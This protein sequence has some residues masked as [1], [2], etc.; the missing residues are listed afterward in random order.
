MKKLILLLLCLG[1]WECTAAYPEQMPQIT[2]LAIP[3]SIEFKIVEK[4]GSGDLDSLTFNG[5]TLYLH[6][7]PVLTQA[8]IETMRIRKDDSMSGYLKSLLPSN[9]RPAPTVTLLIRFKKESRAR[10]NEL[11]TQYQGQRMAIIINGSLLQAP[12]IREP[13]KNGEMA[14]TLITGQEE[15]LDKK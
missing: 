5:E 8:D 9:A 1:L 3:S 11:T 10:L 7:E 2:E 4:A 13:L 12:V 14:I 15:L 6:K